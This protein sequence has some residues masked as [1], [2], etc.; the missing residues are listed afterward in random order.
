MGQYAISIHVYNIQCLIELDICILRHVSLLMKEILKLCL[1]FKMYIVL[2]SC[3]GYGRP[4]N[5]WLV[6]AFV[7]LFDF[8]HPSLNQK[9]L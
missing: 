3:P 4:Q 5:L 2:D 8:L 1:Y 9:H 6:S 7:P